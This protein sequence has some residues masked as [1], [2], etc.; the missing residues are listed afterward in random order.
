MGSIALKELVIGDVIVGYAAAF[1]GGGLG[2]GVVFG[3]AAFGGGGGVVREGARGGET[4]ESEGNEKH[5]REDGGQ[6]HGGRG[7]RGRDGV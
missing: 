3:L 5:G 4:E 6:L 7:D 2:E 1:V